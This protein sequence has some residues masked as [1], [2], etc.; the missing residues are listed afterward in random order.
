[1]RA[2]INLISTRTPRIARL[3]RR[4]EQTG[5]VAE[6]PSEIH[7]PASQELN[8]GPLH[9]ALFVSKRAQTRKMALERYGS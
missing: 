7:L 5:V 9:L 4:L 8:V 3:N 6:L 1:M 2:Q